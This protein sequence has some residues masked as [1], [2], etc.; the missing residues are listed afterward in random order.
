MIADLTRPTHPHWRPAL[1]NLLLLG[2]WLGLFSPV[3]RY[4]QLIFTQEDFRTNQL[5]LLGI[6][7]LL[8]WHIH[9]QKI[10]LN[11][12]APLAW[13]PW[14]LA[15][16]LSTAVFFLLSER[17]LDINMLSALL[18]GLGSYA[19]LGL[20][21]APNTWRRGLPV[22]L[23]LIGV[24]PF[25]AHLQT[26]V[27]YPMRLATAALVQESLRLF[28]VA[29]VGVDTILLLENGV[30]KVDLPCSGVQSLWTGLLFL[31]TATWLEQKRLGGRWLLTAFV[32]LAL[33]FLTNFLRVA[34]LVGVGEV[35]GWRLLAEMIHVPLGVLGFVLACAG[36][37][38][39]LRYFVPSHAEDAVATLPEKLA[40]AWLY[41]LLWLV[42]LAG[43][44]LYTPRPV[45]GLISNTATAPLTFPAELHLT[46]EPLTPQERA[47]LEKD[48]ADTA[49]R[50]RFQWRDH[51]GSLMLIHSR[52]WRAH[53]RP[54]RCFEVYGLDLYD[55]RPHLVRP[56]FPVRYV[57][58]GES[59]SQPRYTAAYWFQSPSQ[60][61]DDYATRI[62]ADVRPQP[63][64]WVLV[65]ILFDT[66]LPPHD[67]DAQALYEA[68]HTAV[69]QS[70]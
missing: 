39:L 27:G 24:L 55:S 45:Q 42:L 53:H 63:E 59:P 36:S 44:W 61:T 23:L 66:H 16:V 41:P 47:W 35:L 69:G 8:G 34:I 32:L 26:F 4:L 22:A 38:L 64:P 10:G 31:L 54:E 17:Y 46:P 19:L 65:S 7:L 37:L 21:V 50:Y 20:W 1:A 29:S 67:P 70:Q 49:V 60:T 40:P 57:L 33:L 52:T 28:G 6:L 3:L 43:M 51:T 5:L 18:F 68:L 9:Q 25:G 11:L 58:L 30:A 48:G 13:R 14:P 56:D 2:L 12:A 15:L 62:W